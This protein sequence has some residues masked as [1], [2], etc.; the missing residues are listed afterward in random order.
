MTIKK[1]KKVG[2][3]DLKVDQEMAQIIFQF[4]L[5]AHPQKSPKNDR[6]M[7]KNDHFI[8]VV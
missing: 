8:Y 5:F 7:T 3:D 1:C 6:K 4:S 2:N